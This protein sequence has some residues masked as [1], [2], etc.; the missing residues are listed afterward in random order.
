MLLIPCPNCG[1][2]HE[3][4]F[5]YGGDASKRPPDTSAQD[6]WH[7]FVYERGNPSGVI[8]EFWHHS[9]GCGQWVR[10]KRDTRT[11]EFQLGCAASS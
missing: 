7:D 10:L 2:R 11:N 1:A 9:Y 8:E 6:D 5:A 4:E 3:N